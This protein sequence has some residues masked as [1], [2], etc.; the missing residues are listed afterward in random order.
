MW[1]TGPGYR[2]G[3]IGCGSCF[4]VTWAAAAWLSRAWAWAPSRGVSRSTR[5]APAI[6]SRPSSRP[7]APWW[8]RPTGMAQGRPRRC[9]ARCSKPAPWRARI[10]SWSPRPASGRRA[11]DGSST[12]PDVGCCESW[13][14]HWRGWA[15]ITSTCGWLMR[16]ATASRWRRRSEPWSMPCR[17]VALATS[18]SPTTRVGRPRAPFRCWSRLGS[19]WWPTRSSI[20]CCTATESMRCCR[21]RKR[22]ASGCWRGPRRVGAF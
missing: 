8:T 19:R 14:G 10:S 1:V 20:R 22:W 17:P 12:C 15:P 18:G 13:T 3:R 4:P 6:S 9:S 11:T 2:R 7:V 5:R 21:L 16:G